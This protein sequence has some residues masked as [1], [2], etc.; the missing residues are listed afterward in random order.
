MT[1]A[2]G[3]LDSLGIVFYPRMF[4]WADAGAHQL[5]RAA[6]LPMD[7]LLEERKMS[8]GLV[9]AASDFHAP[10]RYAE[11]LS[12][13]SGVSKL[14]GRTVE[15][16]HRLIRAADETPVATILEVRVC[17]DLRDPAK[18]RAQALPDDVAGALRPFLVARSE[19]N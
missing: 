11:R 8:F 3:N 14:G 19:P 7:R 13:R 15:L 9:S 18:I 1:V 4:A 12:C 17:M 5:F 6:G 2:E 16:T 10:A